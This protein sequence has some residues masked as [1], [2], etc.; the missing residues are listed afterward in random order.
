MRNN[1]PA[2]WGGWVS[3]HEEHLH[4]YKQR[5]PHMNVFKII[6][7]SQPNFDTELF[8]KSLVLIIQNML[9]PRITD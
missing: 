1:V 7:M 6:V 2:S 3:I 8:P 5:I 9:F 4:S